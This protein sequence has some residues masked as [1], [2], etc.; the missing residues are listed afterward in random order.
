MLDWRQ[1][2]GGLLRGGDMYYDFGKLAHNLVVNH[3]I[4]SRNL[5][6]ISTEG[7]MITCD[8][9]RKPHLVECEKVLETFLAEQGFD[10]KKV[11]VIRA[12]IWLSMS[13]L[14]HDAFNPFLFYFGKLHLWQA[15]QNP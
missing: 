6:A 14:H 3:D 4:I 15:L 11:Q 13:P 7:D 9:Q 2:F 5:F 12:L 10:K 8:I 1:D